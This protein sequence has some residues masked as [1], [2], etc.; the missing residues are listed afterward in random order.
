MFHVTKSNAESVPFINVIRPEEHFEA[1]GVTYY[2]RS[3]V[4]RKV[5]VAKAC[6]LKR[7]S[8]QSERKDILVATGV[9]NE[10]K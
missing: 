7:F 9:D 2:Y 8:P 1:M 4:V 6:C 10:S 5:I 3:R